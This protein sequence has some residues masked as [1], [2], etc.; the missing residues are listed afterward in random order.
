[1]TGSPSYGIFF[2][3]TNDMILGNLDLRLSGGSPGI[4]IRVDTSGRAGSDTTFVKNLRIDR[5]YG[6]GMSSQLVETYGVDGIQIGTVEGN[7][8][9]E[10]GVLL[11]RSINAEVGEVRCTNCGTG[12]GYA[13][14]RIANSAG[15]ING[16]YPVGNI[17]VGKVYARGGGRGI[18]S[19]SASGGLTIDTVDI[20]DTGN[21]PI[22]LENCT[23]T[24]IAAVSGTISKGQVRIAGTTQSNIALKNLTLTNGASVLQSPCSGT[25]T[26]TATN[27]TGGTVT[28][29]R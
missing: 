1:M 18:F 22:L 20:A 16:S 12:T 28:M 24:T 10:C 13:A 19:V 3:G 4:A 8:V 25:N 14:F 15:R 6:S 23:N 5:V 7:S 11:N 29:C 2:R 21:N 9:G 27:V 17:H 26:C